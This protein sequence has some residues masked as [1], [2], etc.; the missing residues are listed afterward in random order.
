M[1]QH[2]KKY[3]KDYIYVL[4]LIVLAIVPVFMYQANWERILELENE[5]ATLSAN[6]ITLEEWKAL[7]DYIE[8][9]YD[10][11]VSTVEVYDWNIDI[12]EERYE[13]LS[14]AINQNV[15]AINDIINY[16]K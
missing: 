15:N 13:I 2:L 6:S 8:M 9:V 11:L 3:L 7:L 16:L 1:K 12:Y 10:D 5:V 14:N 4:I